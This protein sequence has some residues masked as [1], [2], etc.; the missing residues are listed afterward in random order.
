MS[1]TYFPT[2]NTNGVRDLSK[3]MTLGGNPYDG[4]RSP[5]EPAAK[6]A[7]TPVNLGS[8]AP[9]EVISSGPYSTLYMTADP[10]VAYVPA[11]SN[12]ST[13]STPT[14]QVA[15]PQI[16]PTRIIYVSSG[17]GTASPAPAPVAAAPVSQVVAAPGLTDQVASWLG[18]TTSIG[19]WSIPNAL[20]AGAVV[21][22][23]AMFMGGGNT[24]RR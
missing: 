5:A 7:M 23:A 21:L 11:P 20:L 4:Y 14:P 17:G 19:S 16:G 12:V 15:I 6:A 13:Q 22:G 18:G 1:R 10:M 8:I 2:R 24:K 9:E 3:S